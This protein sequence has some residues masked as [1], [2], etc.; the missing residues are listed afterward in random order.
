MMAQTQPSLPEQ[1]CADGQQQQQ[2]E[3]TDAD[4]EEQQWAMAEGHDQAQHDELVCA[5][6]VA[7]EQ[8][9]ES[10]LVIEEGEDDAGG[11]L[12]LD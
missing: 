4:D 12:D 8:P 9:H 6:N 3:E 10:Q 5:K 11:L 2:G 1:K 7:A